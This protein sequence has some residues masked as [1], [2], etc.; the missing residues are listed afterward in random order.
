MWWLQTSSMPPCLKNAREGGK[1]LQ[2]C[3]KSV[4][5][6]KKGR[7]NKKVEKAVETEVKRVLVAGTQTE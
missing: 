7:R 3:V 5:N 6:M 2:P 1:G 4:A